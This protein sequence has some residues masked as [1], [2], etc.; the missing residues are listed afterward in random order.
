MSEMKICI[1]C[2]FQ[3]PVGNFNWRDK[4]KGVRHNTCKA[5]HSAYRRQHYLDNKEMYKEKARRWNDENQD[6]H[7]MKVRRYAFEYLL[8]HPCVDCGEINPLTLQ[9]DHVRGVKKS[10]VSLL[11]SSTTSI[12]RVKE[13]IAKCDVRCANCHQIKTAKEGG[14][15]IID[16]MAEYGLDS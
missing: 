10:T 6:A 4:K 15:N 7:R 11:I 9:F 1:K 16:L 2:D 13:E 12:K 8:A 14:W 5:C 3:Q